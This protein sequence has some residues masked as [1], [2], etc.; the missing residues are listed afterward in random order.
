MTSSDNHES[1]GEGDMSADANL[2]L[3]S[4]VDNFASRLQRR[5][6][7]KE[8]ESDHSE[9]AKEARHGR[10][11][12]A[13]T[14]IRKALQETCKIKLGD[15]FSFDLEV[16]DWEGWPR[17][18][19][20]LIDS[21][22]PERIDYGLIVS[23]NDRNE[24]GT[25]L[26]S[27]RSGEMLGKIQLADPEQFAK[28]PLM[29]KRAVRGYLDII[30]D[31]VLNPKKPE[32]LLE[33]QSQRIEDEELDAV[34]KELQ[35]VD[36]FSEDHVDYNENRVETDESLNLDQEALNQLEEDLDSIDSDNRVAEASSAALQPINFES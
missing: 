17:V 2:S 33:V 19:L 4:T 34:D 27:L 23:A 20:N 13:M 9:R 25:V 14:T 36:V 35:T 30:A 26:L 22:A 29:L 31:Y 5:L 24:L 12:K 1:S 32:E 15:R 10:M 18:E 28:L 6:K 3:E 16:N 7:E 11:L 8:T 21:F